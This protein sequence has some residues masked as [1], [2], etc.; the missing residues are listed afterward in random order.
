MRLNTYVRFC[1][2][3]AEALRFY[4]TE[5]GGK[6]GMIATYSQMPGLS[7]DMARM[8]EAVLH[9]RITIGD[10]TMLASDVLPEQFQPIR[11]VSI[12][13]A[14]DSDAEAGRVYRTLSQGGEVLMELQETFFASSF[15]EVRDRFGVLWMIVCESPMPAQG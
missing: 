8:A 1:G 12:C 5:L 9:A 6:I 10:T 13:I 7:G 11:S 4:E 15:A 2:N 14:V 3:C